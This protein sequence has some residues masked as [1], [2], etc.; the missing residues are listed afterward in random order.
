MLYAETARLRELR[1]AAMK[2]T[3]GDAAR[4]DGS[5]AA[6]I[7]GDRTERRRAKKVHAPCG[8][9]GGCTCVVGVVVCVRVGLVVGARG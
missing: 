2:A 8:G 1:T 9:G 3:V 7:V 4:T 6:R 5:E